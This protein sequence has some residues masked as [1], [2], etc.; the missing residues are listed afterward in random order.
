MLVVVVKR[1][2]FEH[3]RMGWEP[4]ILIDATRRAEG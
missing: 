4:A 2:V 3:E 1:V